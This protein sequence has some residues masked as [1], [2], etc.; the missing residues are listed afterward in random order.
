MNIYR[1]FTVGLLAACLCTPDRVHSAGRGERRVQPGPELSVDVMA[2][3]HP[4]S[5]SIYGIAFLDPMLA[6]EIGLPIRRSSNDTTVRFQLFEGGS[7]YE[8]VSESKSWLDLDRSNHPAASGSAD[9]IARTQRYSEA[10]R[11]INPKGTLLGPGSALGHYQ[12]EDT[13]KEGQTEHPALGQASSYLQAM[14]TY[15][16]E[17]GRRVLAYFAEHYAPLPQN[18]QTETTALEATRSLW[19]TTYVE[20][21]EYGQAHGAIE[22]IPALRRWVEKDYPGTKVALSEYVWGDMT[23]L[24]G[25]LA[26]ADVLGIFGRERLDL[27]CLYG[28]FKATDPGANAFRLYCSYDGR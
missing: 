16:S 25:A 8:M 23:T 15:E 4:I 11:T 22:L 7:L 21:N 19:D 28:T 9:L 17:Q 18:G 10:V 13:P 5:P 27:A 26:E 6:R 3:R 24:I 12:A 2:D 14:R 20:K 1:L